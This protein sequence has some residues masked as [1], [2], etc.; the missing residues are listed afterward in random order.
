MGKKAILLVSVGTSQIDALENTTMKLKK[1]I[2]ERFVEHTCY[3][4]FS[5]KYILKKMRD[6]S[7]EIFLSVSEAFEQMKADGTEEI[8]VQPTY[9]LNGLENDS[10]TEQVAEYKAQFKKVQ[11]AKPL[12]SGK[13]DYI[14]TLEAI[15]SELALEE[16]EA[17]VLVGH[18]SNHLSNATY[19]NLEYTAYTTDHRQVFVGTIEG[20][21]EQ[22]MTKSH[23]MTLRKLGVTGYKKVRLMPLLFVAGYHAMKDIAADSGSWKSILED[24]GYQVKPALIGLGEMESIRKIFVEHLETAMCRDLSEGEVC[25]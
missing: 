21:K 24:A 5:S 18:G 2:E 20:E 4:A 17:L 9:L 12:L 15:L 6:K 7:A 19:Q 11:I 10:M 25:E 16:D 3:V 13:E 23:R 14:K 8:V 1:E 22:E